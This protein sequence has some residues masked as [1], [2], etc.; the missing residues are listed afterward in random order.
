M[1]SKRS[2]KEEKL[3]HFFKETIK[4]WMPH[5]TLSDAATNPAEAN[6]SVEAGLQGSGLKGRCKHIDHSTHD[7]AHVATILLEPHSVSLINCPQR[8]YHSTLWEGLQHKNKHTHTVQHT[9]WVNVRQDTHNKGRRDG[10]GEI[11]CT[12]WTQISHLYGWACTY[13]HN[14]RMNCVCVWMNL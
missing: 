9:R 10:H 11:I 6:Q 2:K 8:I 12:E 4:H 7:R 13:T 1:L 5:V 14:G 3:G